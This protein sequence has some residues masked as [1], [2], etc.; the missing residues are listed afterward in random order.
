LKQ[1]LSLHALFSTAQ[2][3]LLFVHSI[4]LEYQLPH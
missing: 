1:F 3:K 2:M 4:S